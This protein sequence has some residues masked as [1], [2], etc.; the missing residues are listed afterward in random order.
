PASSFVGRERE[1]A[2]VLALMRDRARLVTLTG[3]GGSGKTRLAIEAAAELVPELTAG[4]SWLG[5]ATLR[6]PAL[7]AEPAAP[8]LRA[9]DGLALAVEVAAARTIVL[10]PQQILERISQ[11]LDL[12]KGGRDAEARQQ[13]LR[14]T[15]E[16]SYDLLSPEEQQLFACLS[17]FAGGCTLETAEAL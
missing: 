2:E 13:T 1:V 8:T 11:R 6:D 12:L 17:V 4:A 3:P 10:T 7:V 15:I 14:A 16:W 9:K 5:L